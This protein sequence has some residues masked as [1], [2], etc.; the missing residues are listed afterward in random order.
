MD[1]ETLSMAFSS[2][3]S[4]ETSNHKEHINLVDGSVGS[5]KPRR[6]ACCKIACS[7]ASEELAG[8]KN[9]FHMSSDR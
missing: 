9:P 3:A 2:A 5:R 7:L 4:H 8:S 6:S 1:F